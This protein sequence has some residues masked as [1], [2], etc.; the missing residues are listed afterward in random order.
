MTVICV[1]LARLPTQK[2]L[3]VAEGANTCN[4]NS[5]GLSIRCLMF[6]EDQVTAM[7][8]FWTETTLEASCSCLVCNCVLDWS[9]TFVVEGAVLKIRF[10]IVW[11]YESCTCYKS[12]L[13]YPK[14]KQK[15]LQFRFGVV[16]Q[17]SVMLA[18][19][20]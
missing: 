18:A 3:M 10:V 4:H 5:G 11:K 13:E 8:I 7:F 17:V 16:G 1:K 15:R 20:C 19:Y 2:T 9:P 12:V 6:V 14:L